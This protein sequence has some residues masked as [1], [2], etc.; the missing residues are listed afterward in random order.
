MKVSWLQELVSMFW[1]ME[2]DLVSLKVSAMSSNVFW[3]VYGFGNTLISL[4]ANFKNCAPVLT[5][6]WLG[7]SG[8]GVCCPLGKAWS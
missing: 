3:G 5:K 4:S 1:W 8:I 7:T 2:L 6:Y